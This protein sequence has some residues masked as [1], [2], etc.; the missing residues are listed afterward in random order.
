MANGV[1]RDYRSEDL[2]SIIK[3]VNETSS[4]FCLRQLSLWFKGYLQSLDR[5]DIILQ[6]R[7]LSTLFLSPAQLKLPLSQGNFWDLLSRT[8]MRQFNF[9]P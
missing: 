2:A 9:P 5:F 8:R 4:V 3:H 6:G 7:L 1:F